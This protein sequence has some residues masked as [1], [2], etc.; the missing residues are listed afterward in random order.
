MIISFVSELPSYQFFDF[1]CQST[2]N[3]PKSPK[4]ASMRKTSRVAKP[5]ATK[6]QHSKINSWNNYIR[7]SWKENS[8]FFQNCRPRENVRLLHH[9]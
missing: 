9:T 7:H 1:L 8:N 2:A 6:A 5:S 3:N 4:T